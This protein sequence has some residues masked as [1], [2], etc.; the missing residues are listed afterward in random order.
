MRLR[1]SLH[2]VTV[3][4]LDRQESGLIT[5]AF[6]AEYL[7]MADRPVLGRWY[8]DHLAPDFLEKSSQGLVP[9][10]FHN[11]LPE[12]N[13]ALR[14][15][16]ARRAG[17][18]TNRDF[19]LLAALGADLPGAVVVTPVADGS[20]DMAA[21]SVRVPRDDAPQG[22]LRFSLA[23]MQLKFS[24][25]QAA[26]KLTLPVT[27]IGGRFILKMP[28]RELPNVP[29]NELSMMT[30]ARESGISAPDVRLV[31]WRDV[32]G[33]P[34]ELDFKEEDA[35]LVTRF[36]RPLAGGPRIHQEDF[37]QVLGKR[38]TDKYGREAQVTF[39]RVGKIVARICGEADLA[40]LI[41][42]LVFVVLSANPDAHL[43]NWSILYPDGRRPRL[44]P[45]Y[46]LVSTA[47]YPRITSELAHRLAGEWD[48]R[49]VKLHHFGILASHAG[50][51]AKRGVEWAGELAQRAR[52]TWRRLNRD[53]PLSIAQR[54]AVEKHLAAI[55][56]P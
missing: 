53:L 2:D 43:K 31:R 21:D 24:V 29:A 19:A 54:T 48:L 30:W 41:R 55:K 42:R 15:L 51:D 1:I 3:G 45:A 39:D 46:D 23:G 4:F 6:A 25:A 17:I 27:G 34:P 56:L 36:D 11:Y 22:P 37:A 28:S 44:A 14:E 52:E 38:P 50:V 18:P 5:F 33:L 40:E 35:L 16:L 26:H 8:E 32:E 20:E 10:F 9:P 47:D 49:R 12:P 7:E 13:S